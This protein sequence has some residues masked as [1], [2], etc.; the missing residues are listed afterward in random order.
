MLNAPVNKSWDQSHRNKQL[1][2]AAKQVACV[3]V[4]GNIAQGG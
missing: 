3:D 2:V 1:A 4:G